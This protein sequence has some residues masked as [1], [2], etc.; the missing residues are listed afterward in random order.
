MKEKTVII[1]PSYSG[2]YNILV[3]ELERRKKYVWQTRD[4]KKIPVEEMT[5]EHIHNCLRFIAER[6]ELEEAYWDMQGD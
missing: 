3:R 1:G 6:D 2:A 5:D 4:G